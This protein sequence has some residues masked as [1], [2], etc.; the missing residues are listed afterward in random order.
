MRLNEAFPSNWLKCDDLQGRQV[1]VTIDTYS[2]DEIGEEKKLVLHFKGKEKGL[3]CN[4]TNAG[5]IAQICGT[6]ELDEWTGH[7][8]ILFPTTTP[9]NGKSTP[10]IRVLPPAQGQ[11]APKRTASRTAP[12]NTHLEPEPDAGASEDDNIPF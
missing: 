10:C 3:V 11:P 1:K 5:S 2:F 12:P 4:K 7:Q 6:E 8:I 9:F